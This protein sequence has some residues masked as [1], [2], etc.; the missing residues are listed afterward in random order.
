[1]MIKTEAWVLHRGPSEAEPATLVRE[2][3]SFPDITEDEL[4]VEPIYGCWEGNMTHAL[5]R[6]PI[7]ICRHRGEARVVIGNAGVVRILKTGQAVQ[8]L[9]EGSLAI[10]APVGECDEAGYPKTIFAYDAP[11]TIGLLAKRIKLK[12][13][14]VL[15]LSKDT[16]YSLKQWAAFSLRYPTAWDNWRVAFNCWRVQMSAEVC[17]AP[18]VWGWGGGVTLA[19]LTL[20]QLFGG[21]SAMIAS[22]D[23]RL[24]LIR[25]LGLTPIDRRSF[26]A[27]DFDGQRYKTDLAYRKSY[28][29]AEAAFLNTV[30]EYT[31]GA[32][33]SIFV[34]NI[35]APVHRATLKA[36]ARQGVIT[37]VGWKG[38]MELSV[39]R[40]AECISRHLHIYTHGAQYSPASVHF[41][42]ERGWLPPVNDNPVYDWDS[43]PRLAQDH[44]EGK[45]KT[46]FPLYQVNPV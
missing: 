24:A 42:E 16:K 45:L 22:T 18:F 43:I 10:V 38:G 32:G 2:E 26:M 8:N 46:Y 29:K 19:E 25:G 35:G 37:T 40:A 36:L 11:G 3:F 44:A 28:L 12:Q 13:Q 23:E 34:D 6:S 5:L 30:K 33:V 20:A 21:R 9:S 41:A 1:M 4:L 31:G 7:D 27:L 17:P 15:A 39:T 14:N